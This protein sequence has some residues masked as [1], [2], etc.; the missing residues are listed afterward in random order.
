MRTSFVAIALAAAPAFAEPKLEYVGTFVWDRPESYFGGWSAI[1]VADGGSEFIAIG[2][3]AQIF[4]GKFTRDGD[5][6]AAIPKRPIGALKDVDGVPYFQKSGVKLGDSEGIAFLPD[7]TFAISFE[8]D[9]RIVIYRGDEAIERVPDNPRTK[10]LPPNR[11]VEALAVDASGRLV[12]IPEAM[13]PGAPGFPVWRLE[14]GKWTT[15]FHIQR[16]VGFSPVGADIDVQG[17]LFLLERA[18]R[19]VGFQ[20]RIRM[21]DMLA[22]DPKGVIIWQPA[23]AKFDNLEGL[24]VWS[25]ET[26]GQWLTLISDDNHQRLQETQIVEFRLT[27]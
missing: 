15:V 10:T 24:S 25:D 26:G 27:D 14:G 21:F 8:R 9:D 23:M 13:P 7:G 4:Q 20:S 18:F 6:I 12:A 22:G 19:L 1:E 3:N 16:S 5:A 2:D 11:G 17:R